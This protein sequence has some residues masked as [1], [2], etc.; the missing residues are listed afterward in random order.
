[1]KRDLDMLD[2]AEFDLLIVGGGIYGATT[3]R[4]AALSGL[5][6]ALIDRG[7]FG[8]ATSANSLK[9]IHGGLRYLQH[10]DFRRMRRSIRSRSELLEIA[11]HLVSPLK[12]VVPIYGHYLKG[13]V[14]VNLALLVNDLVGWNR[15]HLPRSRTISKK[16]CLQ[17]LPGISKK[18]LTGGAVWY[19]CIANNTE[20]LTLEF[21]L[22]AAQHGA[23]VANYVE[24]SQPILIGN[25][26]A[27]VKAKDGITGRCLEITSKVV[28]NAAGPWIN[29]FLDSIPS[30]SRPNIRW[31]KAVNIFIKKSLFD[32]YAAGF[33]S[34]T[35]IRDKDAIIRKGGRFFFCVP[36]H[37]GSIIGTTY[38]T[39]SGDPEACRASQQDIIDLLDEINCGY[40]T[41]NLNVEDVSFNHVGLVPIIENKHPHDCGVQPIK[42]SS[43]L[44][45]EQDSQLKG[46]ITING[47]KYTTA[48]ELAK[49]TVH[50]VKKKLGIHN[51][52]RPGKLPLVGAWVHSLK[53]DTAGRNKLNALIRPDVLQH[54]KSVY[55][56]RYISVI[57]IVNE[58]RRFGKHIRQDLPSI[59]AEIIHA[60]REEMAQ[61]LSDV[62]MRRTEL[63]NSGYPG[64]A[65]IT[66]CAE[67]MGRELNWE[68][69]HRQAEIDSVKLLFKFL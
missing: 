60:I 34:K 26:V 9:I 39:Y 2:K 65:V 42:R 67:I 28:V 35:K 47:V 68:K 7:D 56:S 37:D 17:Y 24:A 32:G 18:G 58:E 13:R 59:Q 21:V 14:V 31:A 69:K 45:H 10:G 64:A 63:G 30:I 57:N 40:P 55:G 22:G 4:Q 33:E 46:I 11:P 51:R 5:K 15:N 52:D 12:F 62:I 27:G 41:A 48:I 6:V 29:Q 66:K 19:D 61:N 53:H 50:L 54:L 16:Q 36:W 44:D 25:L 1:M 43:I 3:A 49:D 8:H 20:R 23:S 38:E